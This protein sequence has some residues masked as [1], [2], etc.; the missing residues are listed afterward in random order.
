MN[1]VERKC[2]FELLAQDEEL[3][4]R[5]LYFFKEMYRKDLSVVEKD[6][7]EGLFHP[8]NYLPKSVIQTE[9]TGKIQEFANKYQVDPTGVLM[10]FAIFTEGVTLPRY[11]RGREKSEKRRRKYRED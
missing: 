3:Y 6:R 2:L 10:A 4:Y 8:L 9:V 1:G 11:L 5:M 7:K